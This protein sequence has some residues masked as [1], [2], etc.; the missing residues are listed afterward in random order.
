MAIILGDEELTYQ[1]QLETKEWKSRRKEILERD[2]HC[3][4]FCGKGKC[5]KAQI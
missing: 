2:D 1:E 4:S 5:K 3:C